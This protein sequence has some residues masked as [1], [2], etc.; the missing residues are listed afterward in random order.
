MQY[1]QK[2][3]ICWWSKS[4]Q[5]NARELGLGRTHRRWVGKNYQ[6]E[7][8]PLTTV[9]VEDGGEG[10]S[11]RVGGERGSRRVGRAIGVFSGLDSVSWR[12]GGNI[13]ARIG[14]T[15]EAPLNCRLRLDR[16]RAARGAESSGM[17]ESAEIPGVARLGLGIRFFSK[18][19]FGFSVLKNFGF[20][21]IRNR[22]VF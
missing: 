13:G 1:E 18:L 2:Q 22:S 21:N 11:S 14:D 10:G 4:I 16:Q 6:L 15:E 3:H 20:S 9:N 8:Y 17:V 12:S 5:W 19:R 7:R